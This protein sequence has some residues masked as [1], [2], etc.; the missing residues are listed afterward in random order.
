MIARRIG[1]ILAVVGGVWIVQGLGLVP[2]GSFMDRN[3]FWA[4]MGALLATTGLGLIAAGRR[5]P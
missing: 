5:K 2:T 3:P 1:L 4:L